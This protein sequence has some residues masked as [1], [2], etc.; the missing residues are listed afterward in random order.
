LLSSEAKDAANRAIFQ[1]YGLV[2]KEFPKFVQQRTDAPIEKGCPAA[3]LGKPLCRPQTVEPIGAGRYN[4]GPRIREGR[5][6]GLREE[7]AVDSLWGSL[8]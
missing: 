2:S 5:L 6:V 4:R 3:G 1:R 7:A 8:S